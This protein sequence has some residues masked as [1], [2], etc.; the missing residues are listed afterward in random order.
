MKNSNIKWRLVKDKLF[1]IMVIIMSFLVT[2]PLFVILYYIFK[3]GINSI[4][5]DFFTRLPKPMGE[6]G[7]GIINGIIGSLLTIATASLIAI[8]IAVSVGVYLSEYK[9]KKLSHYVRLCTEILQGAPSIV[10]G[11]VAYIWIVKP[12]K[13]F[14]ALSGAIALAIMMLP[15]IIRSTEETLKMIPESLKEASLS[16]GVPYSKTILKVVLPCGLNGILTGVILSVARIAGETAP[17]L[18]TAFGSPFLTANIFKPMHSMPL[19][20]FNYASSPYPQDN[21]FAWGVSLVL[22]IFVLILNLI[23]KGVSK[24]WKIQF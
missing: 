24:K 2:I 10:L 19:M 17:L 22:C 16:L 12:L 13:H 14:S 6:S 4:N 9:H 8:P 3:M 5:W 15:V 23:A 18:F 7:G 21:S 11:I 1:L 20:I